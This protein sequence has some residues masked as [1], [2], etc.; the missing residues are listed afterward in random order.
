MKNI[1]MLILALSVLIFLN[2]CSDDI[3][4]PEE[5]F[6]PEG[7]VFIDGTGARF[8]Q[9]F[10]GTF[11]PGSDE[12][13]KVPLGDETDRLKIKFLNKNGVEIDPPTS[14]D[15]TLSWQIKDGSKLKL[16]Q[17]DGEEWEFH[18]IGLDLGETEIQFHVYHDGHSDVRSGFIKV[19]VEDVE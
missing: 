7:W 16:E 14:E 11:K 4:S 3:N 17:H 18:L 9:I 19:K 12:Q 6:E 13:F 10:Q 5:H 2:S 8:M 1:S 15:Y